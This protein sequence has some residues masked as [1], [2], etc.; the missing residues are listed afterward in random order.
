MYGQYELKAFID[1]RHGEAFRE[2][3]T[4]RLA[5]QARSDDQTRGLRRVG[6]V[7]RSTLAP[8]LRGARLTA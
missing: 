8:L 5:N 3:Q 1:Q 2:A 7:W 4:R 6:L